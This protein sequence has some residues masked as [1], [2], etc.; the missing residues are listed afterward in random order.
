M[1][2][3]LVELTGAAF[4]PAVALGATLMGLFNAANI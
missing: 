4:N 2:K 3:C 1:N